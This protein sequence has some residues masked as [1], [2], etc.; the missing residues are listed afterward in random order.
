MYCV[1]GK[2]ISV[3]I[4]LASELVEHHSKPSKAVTYSN[5]TP[6]SA[7]E[8]NVLGSDRNGRCEEGLRIRP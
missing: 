3:N 6:G 7:I 5:S 4:S 1:P 2:T 8:Y